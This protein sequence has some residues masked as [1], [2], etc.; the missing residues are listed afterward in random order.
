M[1][2]TFEFSSSKRAFKVRPV[3]L[4]NLVGSCQQGSEFTPI[5]LTAW[6][7]NSF[8]ERPQARRDNGT[9]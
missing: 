5:L 4:Y 9:V 2:L 1:R 8:Q 3:H 7:K 6:R